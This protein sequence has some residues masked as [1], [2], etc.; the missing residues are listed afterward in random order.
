[1]H[2]YY[3][4]KRFEIKADKTN[5]FGRF[6]G[7]MFR[8]RK[9]ENL[10][11]DFGLQGKRGLHSIF[12]FFPFLVLWLDRGNKVVDYKV[13]LPFRW[14]ISTERPF[15]KVIELPFNNKNRK[16]V[17]FFVGKERFK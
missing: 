12:V 6:R 8:S 15:V 3:K 11:F 16:I 1:M 7:L 2:F 13:C 10:L 9:S 14:R 5:F 4:E 17:D